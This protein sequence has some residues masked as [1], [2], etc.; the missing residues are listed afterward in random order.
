MTPT[1]L[2]AHLETLTTEAFRPELLTGSKQLKAGTAQKLVLNMISTITM[3]WLGKTY[4][5]LTILLCLHKHPRGGT[6]R[7]ACKGHF[8][9]ELPHLE[10]WSSSPVPRYGICS[11]WKESNRD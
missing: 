4:G 9:R 5:K 3:I 11:G 2:R 10:A 1:E 6:S 8:L 7:R